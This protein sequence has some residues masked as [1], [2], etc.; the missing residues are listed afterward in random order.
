MGLFKYLFSSRKVSE[1]T[2]LSQLT[3]QEVEEAKAVVQKK[4]YERADYDIKQSNLE[5]FEDVKFRDDSR[6]IKDHERTEK[7]V[8]RLVKKTLQKEPV[9]KT[10][11]KLAKDLYLMDSTARLKSLLSW[12]VLDEELAAFNRSYRGEFDGV[13]QYRL[14]RTWLEVQI[15]GL[16]PAAKNVSVATVAKYN[17]MKGY[18]GEPFGF[19]PNDKPDDIVHQYAHMIDRV[20]WKIYTTDLPA[21]LEWLRNPGVVETVDAQVYLLHHALLYKLIEVEERL[22]MEA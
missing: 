8:R 2:G 9:D 19:W 6:L 4:K 7:L 12:Q 1:E 16:D 21:D 10:L 20:M 15:F 17:V 13:I 18:K 22:K 14:V 11:G 3:S 5:K